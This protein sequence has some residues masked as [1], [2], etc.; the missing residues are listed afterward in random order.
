VERID[1]R[2]AIAGAALAVV[3]YVVI[4]VMVLPLAVHQVVGLGPTGAAVAVL[5]SQVLFLTVVGVVVARLVRRRSGLATRRSALSTA[6]VAG[7]AGAVVVL[8]LGAAAAAATS[9]GSLTGGALLSVLALWLA[10]PA[11][12]S[13]LVPPGGRARSSYETA[14]RPAA[15]PV[16]AVPADVAQLVRRDGRV[17]YDREAGAATLEGLGI[18]IL[19]ALLVGALLATMTP[20]GA[21][22]S[23]NVKAALCRIVT[24]GQGSC[25]PVTIADETHKPQSPC[26]LSTDTDTHA[27]SLD[28]TFVHVGGGGT[29]KV[30][31]MSDGTYRVSMEGGAEGGVTAGLGG[32]FSVTVNDN[33]YGGEASLDAAAYAMLTAGVSWNVSGKSDKDKLVNYL[34]DERNWAEISSAV[35]GAAGP[36]GAVAGGA[37]DVGHHIWNWITGDDYAPPAPDEVYGQAGVGGDAGGTAAGITGGASAGVDMSEALGARVDTATGRTTV[38]FASTLSGDASINQGY[39]EAEGQRYAAGGIGQVI[40]GV[41]LGGD[42]KPVSITAQA[43]AAGDA[44]A[45]IN[46]IFAGNLLD[47]SPSGGVLYNAKVDLTDPEAIR[48][49]SDVLN[50]LGIV[51]TNNP[52][53]SS[54][55]AFQT[56]VNAAKR[57]GTLTRQDV[58]E[59]SNTPFAIDASG[60]VGVELGASYEMSNS[61]ITS[62]NASYFNGKDWVPWSECSN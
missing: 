51:H 57:D 39:S 55:D 54:I 34:K 15:R 31:Q 1:T 7:G 38:Y 21:W 58:T 16:E 25:A 29:I 8:L 18:T 32:G 17:P 49:G 2:S 20:A 3:L 42:G 30:E 14:A 26:V 23:D 53:S 36:L 28:V 11:L 4:T 6:L 9:A 12:G 27:Y 24:L 56:F 43:L 44:T 48:I 52:V 45:Q 59:G 13:A 46:S 47:E 5:A 33:T 50:S 61:N 10:F 41:E 35:S 60:K 22:L 37:T 40:V 19:A 62:T